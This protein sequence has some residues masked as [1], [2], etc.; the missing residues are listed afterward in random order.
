[1]LVGTEQQPW[2]AASE[3]KKHKNAIQNSDDRITPILNEF[4]ETRELT[5]RT[6]GRKE[7]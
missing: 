7:P 1:M 4:P 2:C 5:L 3:R 6:H